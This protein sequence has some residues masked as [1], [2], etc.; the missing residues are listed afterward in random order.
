MRKDTERID[1]EVDEYLWP[2]TGTVTQVDW[3]SLAEELHIR[4]RLAEI[5]THVNDMHLQPR[6]RQL[7]VRSST[8]RVRAATEAILAGPPSGP[9]WA[10]RL[11]EPV[12]RALREEWDELARRLFALNRAR[13]R[14]SE[15]KDWQRL[16]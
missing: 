16:E 10:Q 9:P 11:R 2:L 5:M 4:E 1:A 15:A 3:S 14:P 7:G 8:E 13:S 6:I 12:P